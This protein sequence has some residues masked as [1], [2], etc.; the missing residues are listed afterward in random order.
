MQLISAD[1]EEVEDENQINSSMDRN[2]ASMEQKM[3]AQIDKLV[4]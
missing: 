1:V 3:K 4:N 2:P